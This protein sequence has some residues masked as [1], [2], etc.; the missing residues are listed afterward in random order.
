MKDLSTLRGFRV[1][2]PY[3]PNSA[4]QQKCTRCFPQL[5]GPLSQDTL[6]TLMNYFYSASLSPLLLRGAC[7]TSRILCRNFTPMHHR[8]LRAKDLPKVLTWRLERDSKS[9]P[10]GL[11]EALYE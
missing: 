3:V 4:R 7:D 1:C 5:Y 9:R 8:Q 11:E 6:G 2:V 10:F